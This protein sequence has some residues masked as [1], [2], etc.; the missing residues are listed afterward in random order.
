LKPWFTGA[1]LKVM[2]DTT[3]VCNPMPDTV[4]GAFMVCCLS[5]MHVS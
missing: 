1:G 4:T 3:P 2:L 5:F